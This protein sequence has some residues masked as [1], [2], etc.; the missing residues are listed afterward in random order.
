M[1]ASHQIILGAKSAI[2]F[3][4]SLTGSGTLYSST[5]DASSSIT[6]TAQPDGTL[7]VF[8]DVTSFLQWGAPTTT[9]I[10]QSYWVRFTRDS[11]STTG[12]GGSGSATATTGWLQLNVAR[13]VTV[14]ANKVTGPGTFQSNASYTI[15]I[16]TDSGGTN[17]VATATAY[18]LR[19]SAAAVE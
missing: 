10:G 3:T 5:G 2:P 6:M 12:S 4:P 18:Q 15:D 9:D 8:G 7:T 14:I 13:S 19:A 17:I 11:F 16:A 1:T